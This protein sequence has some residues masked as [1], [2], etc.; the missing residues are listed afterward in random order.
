MCGV[1]FWRSRL[2]V[3]TLPKDLQVARTS[4]PARVQLWK[5]RLEALQASEK[6]VAQFCQDIPCSVTSL[7]AWRRRFQALQDTLQETGGKQ[8]GFLPVVLRS[9]SH[10][11]VSFQLPTGITIQVPCEATNAIRV[12]LEQIA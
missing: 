9:A 5:E 4:N 8:P 1:G 3:N 7:Y 10:A 12:V 2:F 11:S 6:T